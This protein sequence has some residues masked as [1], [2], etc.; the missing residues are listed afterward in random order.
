MTKAFLTHKVFKHISNT[1][2]SLISILRTVK[3]AIKNTGK[4]PVRIRKFTGHGPNTGF[5][6]PHVHQSECRIPQSHIIKKDI[7]TLI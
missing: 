2:I 1:L 4:N 3:I 5:Y 7:F 6:G